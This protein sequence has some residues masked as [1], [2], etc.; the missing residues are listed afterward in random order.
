LEEERNSDH[1][2]W[3]ELGRLARPE[4]KPLEDWLLADP[5]E[6]ALPSLIPWKAL[7]RT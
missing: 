2:E 4:M 6:A 1:R 3:F 7:V 5:A